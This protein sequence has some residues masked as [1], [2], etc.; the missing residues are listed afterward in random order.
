MKIEEKLTLIIIWL[1]LHNLG[2]LI[3]LYFI[4][5]TYILIFYSCK[6]NINLFKKKYRI[7]TDVNIDESEWQQFL[8]KQFNAVNNLKFLADCQKNPDCNLIS[9][10]KKNNYC[11]LYSDYLIDEESNLINSKENI[12]YKPIYELKG[13]KYTQTSLNSQIQI[14]SIFQASNKNLACGLDNGSILILSHVDLSFIRDINAHYSA[15][16]SMY[17]LK[18]GSLVSGSSDTNIKIWDCST[19]TLINTLIGHTDMVYIVKVLSN[20]DIASGSEDQTVRIWDSSTGLIKFT[21]TFLLHSS[22]VMDLS[23]LSNNR[24]LVIPNNLHLILKYHDTYF[25]IIKRI[26]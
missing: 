16:N 2:K 6:S 21:F 1:N 11:K 23:E 8:I 15:V 3:F 25:C 9:F 5:L 12:I 19:R 26:I 24:A 4:I 10:N 18:N 7:F 17:K 14:H 13:F 22:P 20:N